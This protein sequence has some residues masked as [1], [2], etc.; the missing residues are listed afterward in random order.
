MLSLSECHKVAHE[1]LRSKQEKNNRDHEMRIQLVLEEIPRLKVIKE[2][3]AENMREFAKFAFSGDRSEERFKE[4]KAKSIE[5]Q[6]ERKELLKKYGYPETV[7]D[8]P[9]YCHLCKDQGYKD[10]KF[11]ECYKREL[12]EVFIENSNLMKIYDNQVFEKFDLDFFLNEDG[13]KGAT[14]EYMLKLRSYMMHYAECFT[15]NSENLLFS[16]VPGCGKSFMSCAIAC[17]VINNGFFVYYTPAQD[18]VAAFEA[19]RFERDK[20]VDTSVYK[21]CDLLIIDDL[22][23]EFKTQ[24][25][26]SVLYN[27]IND[28]IN[29]KKPM[30]I[31]TNFTM[32]ELRAT[33]HDR[34]CSRLV[35]EFLNV[36]FTALDI[37]KLKKERRSKVKR[38]D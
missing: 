11:C 16:G 29:M 23:T 18:M 34:L 33:Y 4:Y 14:Y 24:F 15:S 21:D 6:K 2:D 30:I 38:D 26:D 22:G 9:Y 32:E 25:T 35:N 10:N 3:L 7:F 28:R 27:V 31:S 20:N 37:R 12:S 13:S 19:E 1:R 17:E 8:E 36:N 5:L